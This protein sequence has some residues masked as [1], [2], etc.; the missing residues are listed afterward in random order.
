[1]KHLTIVPAGAGAGKTYRIK[2]QLTAWVRDGVVRPDRILA[3][4][5]TEAAAGELRERIRA[6]LLDAGM[7][8]AALAV[9]SAYVSTIHGL[10]LR[11]LT[12]HAFAAGASPQ[13]RHLSDAERDLLIR[14][15]LARCEV[16]DPVMADPER[17]GYT[18]N[19]SA[20]VEDGFRSAVLRM[21]DLLRGLGDVGADPLLIDAACDRLHRIHGETA[22]SGHPFEATLRQ[23]ARDML[24]MFP[25]GCT[26]LADLKGG[27]LETFRKDLANLRAAVETDRLSYDWKLWG[28]LRDLRMTKRGC[29]TP[30]DYDAHAEAVMAAA[31]RI[32][33]HPGPR[34]DALLHLRCLIGGAQAIMADYADRKRS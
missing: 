9:E 1:M 23:A 17:Y 28:K 6:S 5:F 27:P 22:D 33:D 24:A 11:I 18:A 30:P 25:K 20:G 19:W 10:G 29:P 32:V 16:L 13:P 14:Q 4:T 26:D 34:D 8:D 21:I 2:E 15:A 31:A 12:E 3:V 7:I